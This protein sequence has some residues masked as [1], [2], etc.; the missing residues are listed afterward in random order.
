[1]S[2]QT[3]RTDLD[4]FILPDMEL[5]VSADF[6]RTLEREL[7]IERETSRLLRV[8]M[9]AR[10][11]GYTEMRKLL[12]KVETALT[13]EREKVRTL[14]TACESICEEWGH[15]YNCW[16][17]GAGNKMEKHATAALAATEDAQ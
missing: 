16:P 6:A 10:D 7:A 15:N 5:V 14:R 1:M 2:T 13:T 4:C 9:D 12:S 17:I 11:E 3:P 8:A